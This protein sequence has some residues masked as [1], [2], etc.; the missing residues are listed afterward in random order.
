[1]ELTEN[2]C[3]LPLGAEIIHC[4]KWGMLPLRQPDKPWMQLPP[5]PPMAI[6]EADYLN[7]MQREYERLNPGIQGL[8]SFEQFLQQAQT[9]RPQIEQ[10]LRQHKTQQY[11]TQQSARQEGPNDWCYQHFYPDPNSLLAWQ[12]QG[13]G[14]SRIWLALEPEQLPYDIKPLHYRDDVPARYR[15]RLGSAPLSCATLQQSGLVMPVSE[16]AKQITVQGVAMNLLKL[17]PKA[18]KGVLLGM[19]CPAD[20]VKQLTHFWRSDMR[21]QRKPLS[22][23]IWPKGEYRFRFK[24]L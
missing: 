2:R 22:Q 5:P 19:N 21:Y 18:V 10:A 4:L 7:H 14:F 15:E 6:S 1:M 9:K 24:A 13:T 12:Q 23:M 16:L 8:L 20:Q 17:P 11:K 3:Y